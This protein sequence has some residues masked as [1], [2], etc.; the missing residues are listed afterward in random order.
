MILS[1]IQPPPQA[2]RLETGAQGGCGPQCVPIPSGPQPGGGQ[3]RASRLDGHT[4]WVVCWAE[5]SRGAQCKV[6]EAQQV[7]K[8]RQ[9]G[10]MGVWLRGP[11]KGQI[12]PGRRTGGLGPQPLCGSALGSLVSTSR[13]WV[14]G[15]LGLWKGDGNEQERKKYHRMLILHGGGRSEGWSGE[16]PETGR[17]G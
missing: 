16:C 14:S 9:P 3:L 13:S 12:S 11:H 17:C 15:P 4:G 5:Y 8:T 2:C 6:T 7:H 10:G 1:K